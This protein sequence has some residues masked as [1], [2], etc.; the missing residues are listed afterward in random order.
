MQLTKE[1]LKK[2]NPLIAKFMGDVLCGFIQGANNVHRA[3]YDADR[4]EEYE[5]KGYNTSYSYCTDWN[6]LMPVCSKIIKMYADNRSDIFQALHKCDITACFVAVVEFLEF[7]N[8]ETRPKLWWS[9]VPFPYD[10]M[11]KG[12]IQGLPA[13]YLPSLEG[14]GVGALAD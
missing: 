12:E 10:P 3:T 7:W 2:A 4:I 8:D 13:Q 5:L 6:Y 1:Y 14:E 9:N 11:P